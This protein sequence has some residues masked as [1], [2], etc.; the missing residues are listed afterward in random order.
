MM[1]F[2]RPDF[3]KSEN[4]YPKDPLSFCPFFLIELPF[5]TKLQLLVSNL[6]FK[7]NQRIKQKSTTTVQRFTQQVELIYFPGQRST[8]I[9]FDY[10]WPKSI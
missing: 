1:S 10:T 6:G 8:S 3:S 9:T 2:R 5:E 4:E 7:K